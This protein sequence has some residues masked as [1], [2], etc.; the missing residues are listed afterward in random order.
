MQSKLFCWKQAVFLKNNEERWLDV[1]IYNAIVAERERESMCK[2]CWQSSTIR[3]I[4]VFGT[5]HNQ[6]GVMKLARR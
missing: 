1:P 2:R 5:L 6:I 3:K 4:F